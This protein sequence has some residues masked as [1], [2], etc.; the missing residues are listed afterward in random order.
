MVFKKRPKKP[1]PV[2]AGSNSSFHRIRIRDISRKLRRGEL[3][4]L[5][6]LPASVKTR[7]EGKPSSIVSLEH[8]GFQSIVWQDSEGKKLF[9]KRTDASGRVDNL[10]NVLQAMM[11]SDVR[12]IDKGLPEKITIELGPSDTRAGITLQLQGL[13][14]EMARRL[15]F[16]GG[17]SADSEFTKLRDDL[18]KSSGGRRS[19]SPYKSLLHQMEIMITLEGAAD[20]LENIDAQLS[21]LDAVEALIEKAESS[22]RK[23]K[24][25]RNAALEQLTQQVAQ[26]K[27][28]LTD[29]FIN[30]LSSVKRTPS[31][32]MVHFLHALQNSSIQ[33]GQSNAINIV[34]SG[35]RDQI[36]KHKLNIT[37]TRAFLRNAVSHLNNA[38]H[39]PLT[40]LAHTLLS[41]LP[42]PAKNEKSEATRLQ[43]NVYGRVVDSA[44]IANLV[45]DPPAGVK[46]TMLKS[47]KAMRQLM[48]ESPQPEVWKQVAA[49]VPYILN[50]YDKRFWFTK[51]P[52]L[53]NIATAAEV[54]AT[55]ARATAIANGANVDAAEAAASDA[56]ATAALDAL[57]QF[58][59]TPGDNGQAMVAIPYL[60]VKMSILAQ[61]IQLNAAVP[62]PA[63]PASPWM[64]SAALNYRK[65]SRQV[66]RTDRIGNLPLNT[67]AP[68]P[69]DLLTQGSGIALIHQANPFLDPTM[70]RS[71]RPTLKNKPDINRQVLRAD[72]TYENQDF[73]T[74]TVETALRNGLP[75]GSGASGSTN[76]ML[77]LMSHLKAKDPLINTKDYL[78]GTMMFLTYDGGHSLQEALWTA[79]QSDKDLSLGLNIGDPD[80]P[81]EFV[82]DYKKLRNLYGKSDSGVR[83]D[84]ALD[85]G[86]AQATDHFS[87]Y[88]LFN[89][90]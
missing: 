39:G 45:D 33:D 22:D 76:I 72:G 38:N 41:Q 44:I 7:L 3:Q 56:S 10:S 47:A 4:D 85:Y 2:N 53:T 46:D 75:F 16:I 48:D 73:P 55:T 8:E 79:N 6:Q 67:K 14:S 57:K 18:E 74:A 50:T 60:L 69:D 19:N 84:A 80:K 70:L 13:H 54:A 64:A 62:D 88:S 30:R 65:I 1:L 77:Y 49:N 36:L 24:G 27:S 90:P 23:K 52:A 20:T 83:L 5:G 29:D 58:L 63:Q 68:T 42:D 21:H 78:L 43:D 59:D 32:V 82:A 28:R 81:N 86:L 40:R 61:Q 51:T 11:D 15:E 9:L 89:T 26:Q 34:E 87:H 12:G 66:G 71:M 37:D 35:V 25:E 17:A 31:E